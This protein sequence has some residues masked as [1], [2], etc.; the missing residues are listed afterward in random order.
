MVTYGNPPASGGLF[1][2]AFGKFLWASPVTS[3]FMLRPATYRSVSSIS[4]NA[5]V[6]NLAS[7]ERSFVNNLASYERSRLEPRIVYLSQYLEFRLQ[8]IFKATTLRFCW[9][10]V[11]DAN[12]FLG[13]GQTKL[14]RILE[15]AQVAA[16]LFGA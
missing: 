1:G 7:Y 11:K 9:L 16:K 13:Q 2:R 3:E 14:K 8:E 4:V 10:K 12:T 6:N 5:F 15:T